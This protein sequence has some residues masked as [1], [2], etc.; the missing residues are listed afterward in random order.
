M[1]FETASLQKR[2]RPCAYCCEQLKVQDSSVAQGDRELSGA[3]FVHE[4]Q[5]KVWALRIAVTKLLPVK[6]LA[7]GRA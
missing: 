6:K 2:I 7:A 5:R 3:V 1:D 4:K